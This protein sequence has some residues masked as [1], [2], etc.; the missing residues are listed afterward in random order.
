MKKKKKKEKKKETGIGKFVCNEK[1]NEKAKGDGKDGEAWK[2][3]QQFANYSWCTGF[4]AWIR[5]KSHCVC[6]RESVQIILRTRTLPPQLSWVRAVLRCIVHDFST[7]ITPISTQIKMP[8]FL[9]ITFCPA[10]T[11]D[12]Y[13]YFHYPR[14]LKHIMRRAWQ[15]QRLEYGTQ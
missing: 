4:I 7:H 8:T 6:S 3:Q 13:K 2:Q 9:T 11:F 12:T 15:L 10:S 14:L 5:A 1:W